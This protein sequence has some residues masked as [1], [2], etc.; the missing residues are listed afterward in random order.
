MSNIQRTIGDL[1]Y[2]KLGIK[3][4]FFNDPPPQMLNSFGDSIPP[5]AI[6]DGELAANVT[7]VDGGMQS[8][9]FESG[10]DGWQILPNGDVEFDSGTF[11][12]D[13]TG[14]SGTFSGDITGATGTFN[15]SVEIHDGD[16]RI[17][18]SSDNLVILMES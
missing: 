16:I 2:N 3:Q 15:G 10:V 13:I 7:M 11:R 17:Y 8:K 1:G 14:S 18:D 5:A 12:G 6:D 9:N 4:R